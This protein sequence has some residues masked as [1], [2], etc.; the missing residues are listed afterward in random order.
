MRRRG[1]R[2]LWFVAAVLLPMS[3]ACRHDTLV[4]SYAATMFTFSQTGA[5]PKDALAAGGSVTLRIANDLSTSGTMVIPASVTG[6]AT[7]SFSLLGTAAKQGDIVTLNLVSDT[8]LRDMQF[9]FDGTALS[10]S[11]TFGDGAVALTLSK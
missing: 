11:G 8:F 9:A 3:I 2:S 1:F 5:A 6:G 4:G 10:G 7:M